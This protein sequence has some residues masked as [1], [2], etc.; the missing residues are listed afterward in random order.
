MNEYD[1]V[2]ET[3]DPMVAI[4]AESGSPASTAL[5]A[6][7]VF[8]RVGTLAGVGYKHGRW[9]DVIVM[10]LSLGDGVSTLPEGE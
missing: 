8:T 1:T 2:T 9:L 4:I 3:G 5:H 7:L 6:R 10:Q